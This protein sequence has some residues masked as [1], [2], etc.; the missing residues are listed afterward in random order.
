MKRTI[1]KGGILQF[2]DGDP[3][4]IVSVACD[5]VIYT[6]DNR[7]VHCVTEVTK[8]GRLTLTLWFTRDHSD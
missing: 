2:Q 4:S 1:Y 3:S 8:G 7:N 6:A 5:V